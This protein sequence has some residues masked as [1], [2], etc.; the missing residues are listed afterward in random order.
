MT[1][2]SR[3]Y[4][5]RI[6]IY[7]RYEIYIIHIHPFPESPCNHLHCK[8][9]QK[10]VS[11]LSVISS[12][13]FASCKY[14]EGEERKKKKSDICSRSLSHL[15]SHTFFSFLFFSLGKLKPMVPALIMTSAENKKATSVSLSV[16]LSLF[17]LFR[18][19]WMNLILTSQPLDRSLLGIVAVGYC[20]AP[21]QRN[22][23][24]TVSFYSDSLSVHLFI[25]AFNLR[26]FGGVES[27]ISSVLV[28]E[29]TVRRSSLRAAQIQTGSIL[30]SEDLRIVHRAH[31]ERR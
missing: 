12:K 14:E 16:F 10:Y 7:M 15:I 25:S 4:L 27:F 18:A 29:I 8:M 2:G 21:P 5:S 19:A 17:S 30:P 3:L 20:K 6:H 13:Q 28:L 9:G 23:A 1:S 22:A 26:P 31:A 24:V 11:H